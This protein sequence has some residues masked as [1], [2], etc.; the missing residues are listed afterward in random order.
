MREQCKQN[1]HTGGGTLLP[2]GI[3]NDRS[4]ATRTGSLYHMP[5][6]FIRPAGRC[7]RQ[8]VDKVPVQETDKEVTAL[9]SCRPDSSFFSQ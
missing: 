3:S 4:D 6:L 2:I 5:V 1:L 9:A 8:T 7:T